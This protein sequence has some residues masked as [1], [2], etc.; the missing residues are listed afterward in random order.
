MRLNPY[1]K[2]VLNPHRKLV[3]NPHRKRRLNPYRKLVLNPASVDKRTLRSLL[4]SVVKW[5][6][7]V[8]GL[9]V[10]SVIG[11]FL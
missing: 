5:L 9:L 8:I 1:R 7:P 6:F 2:L 11:S 10:S 3:L 4:F